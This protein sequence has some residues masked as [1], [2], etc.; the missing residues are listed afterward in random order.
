MPAQNI[1]YYMHF[2]NARVIHALM[3]CMCGDG[4]LVY[5]Y[6][7]W[8]SVH[9]YVHTLILTETCVCV[10]VCVCVCCVVCVRACVCI[11][12]AFYIAEHVCMCTIYSYMAYYTQCHRIHGDSFVCCS[13]TAYV[14]AEILLVSI[15]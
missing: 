11:I 9:A 4:D 10:C 8:H 15:Y 2:P 6:L 1:L 5:M 14:C 12:R 13:Y 3:Q 7:L